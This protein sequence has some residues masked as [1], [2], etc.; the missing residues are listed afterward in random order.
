VALCYSRGV[1]ALK[2]YSFLYARDSRSLYTYRCTCIHSV[3]GSS[4]N[5]PSTLGED[6]QVLRTCKFR[7][8][9]LRSDSYTHTAGLREKPGPFYIHVTPSV[10]IHTHVHVYTQ[11]HVEKVATA[12]AHPR[13]SV[14]RQQVLRASKFRYWSLRNDSY[15]HT[16]VLREKPGPVVIHVTLSI[17]TH[18]RVHVIHTQSEKVPLTPAPPERDSSR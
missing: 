6:E 17:Y 16:G 13:P 14:I 8:W 10:C 9:P 11:S 15:T 2:K 4:S 18:T 12:S 5:A 3:S 1:N 7:S